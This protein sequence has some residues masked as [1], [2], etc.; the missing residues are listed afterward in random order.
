MR[1]IQAILDGYIALKIPHN[2]RSA[3]RLV[4]KWQEDGVTLRE[5]RPDHTVGRWYGGDLVRFCL[6]SGLWTVY[7]PDGDAS[8]TPVS[9]I[10]PS[11]DFERQLEQVELD[12]DGIF[13]VS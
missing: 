6:E 2:V 10:P 12:P 11:P 13:W 9:S 1:R 5:E 4:C 8:W 3:V 7:R